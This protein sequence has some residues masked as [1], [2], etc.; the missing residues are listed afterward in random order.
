MFS[1]VVHNAISFA[2]EAHKGQV[3]KGTDIPYIVHPMA[4]ALLAY[5]YT[6]DTDLAVAA[7]LHDTV[8]DTA[9][10]I[11]DIENA[12]GLK[13]ARFVESVTEENPDDIWSDRK[14]KA[15]A[16]VDKYSS[17]ELMLKG[18]DVMANCRDI[19]KDYKE[20]GENLWTRFNQNGRGKLVDHYITMLKT[21]KNKAMYSTAPFVFIRDLD[22]TLTEMS[23]VFGS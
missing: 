12:F 21:L 20:H 15:L 9:V 4:V 14:K 8:E 1:N 13:V 11:E 16:R 6:K 5:S 23:E 10:T 17:D 19:L 18:C 7:L 22:E 3:R 2:T